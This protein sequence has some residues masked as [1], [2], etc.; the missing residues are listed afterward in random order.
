LIGTEKHDERTHAIHQ[1]K[2]RIATMS[3]KKVDGKK[4][5]RPEGDLSKIIAPEIGG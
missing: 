3:P 5:E 2:D 1:T 4:E